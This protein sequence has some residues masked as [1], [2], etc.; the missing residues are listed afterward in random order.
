M[1]AARRRASGVVIWIL[2]AILAS[3]ALAAD[4]DPHDIYQ[5]TG[6]QIRSGKLKAAAAGATRLREFITRHPEWDPDGIFARELLPSMESRIGRL[7]HTARELEQ[8]TD[9]ALSDTK[10]PRIT[11]DQNAARVFGDWATSTIDRL[12]RERDGLITAGLPS[13]E[14][15]A[16]LLR[17]ESYARSQHL[18]EDDILRLVNEAVTHEVQVLLPEDRRMETVHDRLDQ[19]KKGMMESVVERDRLRRQVESLQARLNAYEGALIGLIFDGSGP[20]PKANTAA[21]ADLRSVFAA[22]LDHEIE[23][24]TAKKSQTH[25][26][27]LTRRESLDRYRRCNRVLTQAGVIE[28]QGQRIEALAEVVERTPLKGPAWRFTSIS[29]GVLG[30]L[31]G[32]LGTAAVGFGW[33]AARRRRRNEASPARSEATVPR[34]VTE[35]P[36]GRDG[37][38]AA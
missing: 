20:L 34:R 7:Q 36:R 29:G 2:G 21:G 14:D 24:L 22:L 15:Q 32:F 26:E 18:L 38:N 9:R 28:D 5:L 30:T 17:T 19:I 25:E 10:P 8:F 12:R 27:Y 37:T 23:T 3:I 35:F 6:E 16:I 13:P 33:A 1:I 31:L 4:P 11:E